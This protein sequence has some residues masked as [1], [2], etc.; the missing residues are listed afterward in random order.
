M[1]LRT[2]LVGSVSALLGIC[3]TMF[4]V[5]GTSAQAPKAGVD[6]PARSH[7]QSVHAEVGRYQGAVDQ[8]YLWLFDTATGKVWKARAGDKWSQA[9]EAM[10]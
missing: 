3:L 5:S 7:A 9:V 6:P 10:Q 2:I 8:S 4:C 1:N